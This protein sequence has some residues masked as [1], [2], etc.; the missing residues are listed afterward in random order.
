MEHGPFIDDLPIQNRGFQ[1]RYVSLPE[2]IYLRHFHYPSVLECV[3][4]ELRP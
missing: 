1:V 3:S 4:L 2:G